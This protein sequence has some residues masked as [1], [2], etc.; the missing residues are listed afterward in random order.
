MDMLENLNPEQRLAV[1]HGEGPALVLA[2]AGSGKTRVIVHR[3]A[4]LILRGASRP[5]NILAVTFTNKAAQEMRERIHRLLGPSRS[6][7]PLISTFHAFCVR[8]LRREIHFLGYRQDFSIYDTDDQKRLM[9][10]ILEDSHREELSAR[11]VLSR[12]SYAKNHNVTPEVYAHRFPSETA[13]EI[14]ALYRTYDS[15]LRKANALDFDDLL[16]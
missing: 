3:I 11:E 9:K 5:E 12:V 13:E 14:A 4:Y 8:L 1:E 2:G 10:Q 7:E 15:R 6:A 16:L